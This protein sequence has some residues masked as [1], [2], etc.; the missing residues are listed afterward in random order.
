MARDTSRVTR[1]LQ[2]YRTGG[3]SGLLEIKKAARAKRKIN[4]EKSM[5]KNQ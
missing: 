2:K 5:M 3:L 1:W 4:D